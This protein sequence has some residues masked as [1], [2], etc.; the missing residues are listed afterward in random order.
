M[1]PYTCKGS[2]MKITS[3]SFTGIIPLLL[4]ATA[5][6][7]PQTA[8]DLPTFDFGSIYQGT[9]VEHVFTIRN[10][11]DAPLTIKS[12]RP[13]CGCTAASITTS[14]IPPGKT[15]AIKASFNST[16]FA[17][18]IQKTVAVDTDDLKF[19][20]LILTLK[21][22]VFEDIQINPKQLNL[23]QIKVN[24][25]TKSTLVIMNK[26]SKPL[27]LTSV[28]SSLAQ[29]IA[30]ADRSLLKPGESSKIFVSISPRSGDRLLSGYLSIMT[31]NP[32][33]AEIQV[34]VYGSLIH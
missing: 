11:G 22:T 34:P 15:G 32:V 2:V 30:K 24:D 3:I 21:G 12:V 33:K 18:T 25:T 8:I 9:K 31:D 10:K 23:G 17:G 5:T 14:V 1:T 28:K 16:N 13:S 6:A 19:P 26:G 4:I 7:V 29:I 20:A 27:Q